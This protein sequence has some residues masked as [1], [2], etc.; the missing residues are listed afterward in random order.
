MTRHALLLSTVALL[1]GGQLLFKAVANKGQIGFG[2]LFDPLFIA[3]L[4]VY[5]LA[6]IS[7][8]PTLRAWPL[9]IAYPATA[10]S[11]ALVIIA[12]IFLFLAKP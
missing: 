5:G 4:A 8:I 2:L 7:W 9:A 1:V 3:A 10:L 11:I 6:T 12:S